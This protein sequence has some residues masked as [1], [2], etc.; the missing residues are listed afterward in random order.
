MNRCVETGYI[1]TDLELKSTTGGV[2]VCSFTVAVRRPHVKDKTD[3]IDCVA[4]REKAEF[5]CKFFKKGSRIEIDGHIETRISELKD[6]T[7]RKYT[8]LYCEDIGFGE[9]KAEGAEEPKESVS[10]AP[11][12]T[13]SEPPKAERMQA[14]ENTDDLPF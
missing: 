6:G 9:K 11:T 10:Q 7:K 1:V 8:E 5:L 12:Q 2:N 4:W 13:H 3:F 14:V